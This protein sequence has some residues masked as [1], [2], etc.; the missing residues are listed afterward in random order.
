MR[1]IDEIII[2]CTATR[3]GRD[4][5]IETFRR[6][7]RARG[8]SDVGYHYIIHLDGS[9]SKGRPIS[10][11]GAHCTGHN[12]NSIGIAYVGGLASDGKTPKDTRTN[13]QK[14]AMRNLLRELH[15]QFPRAT[16][17]GHNEFANKACPCFDVRELTME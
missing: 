10:V 13:A 8:F 11:V 17:H 6:W 7:H 3:E 12:T 16:V 15:T 5:A 2:H 1:P 4:Y 14:T 9:V